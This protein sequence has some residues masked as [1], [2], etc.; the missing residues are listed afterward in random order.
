MF[1]GALSGKRYPTQLSPLAN[2]TARMITCPSET[3]NEN[4]LQPHSTT[5][6]ISFPNQLTGSI[7]AG[8]WACPMMRAAAP[9]LQRWRTSTL[10]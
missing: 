10:H 3:P 9:P 7:S 4:S 1:R 8:T 2:T 6:S 5:G